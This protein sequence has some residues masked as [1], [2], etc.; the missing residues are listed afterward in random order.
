MVQK[1]NYRLQASAV[2]RRANGDGVWL[3]VLVQKPFQ[4]LDVP[5]RS[6]SDLGLH[7]PTPPRHGKG[8]NSTSTTSSGM[9]EAGG[10]ALRW[11]RGFELASCVLLRSY[12]EPS[13]FTW[14]SFS[15][16]KCSEATPESRKNRQVNGLIDGYAPHTAVDALLRSYSEMLR[17]Y[18]EM[19]RRPTKAS[20]TAQDRSWKYRAM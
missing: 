17:S 10:V 20:S 19:L 18:S 13:D 9:E 3:R 14:G 7:G 4:S 2:C 8:I 15:T 12:S 11:R 16:P 5:V 1:A 6:D